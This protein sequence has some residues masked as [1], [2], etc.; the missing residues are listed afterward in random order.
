MLMRDLREPIKSV[1]V[2]KSFC[3]FLFSLIIDTQCVCE[4][5]FS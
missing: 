5:L 4:K 3:F 2:I 1:L